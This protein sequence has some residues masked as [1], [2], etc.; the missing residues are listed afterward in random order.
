MPCLQQRIHMYTYIY[1]YTYICICIY[2][3]MYI[4]ICHSLS[5]HVSCKA[6]QHTANLCKNSASHCSAHCSAHC[7]TLQHTAAHCSTLQQEISG[8][9][10][11]ESSHLTS[12]LYLFLCR[13]LFAD[14]NTETATRRGTATAYTLQHTAAYCNILQHGHASGHHDCNIL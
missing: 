13:L 3:Y 12:Y 11:A 10:N 9:F 5:Q 14:M 8:V 2:M 1:I 6:L 7:N 4:Y